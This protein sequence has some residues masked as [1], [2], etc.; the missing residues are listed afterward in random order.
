MLSIAALVTLF[1]VTNRESKN[2]IEKLQHETTLLSLDKE[3][4]VSRL[5][6]L[7][8]RI[9]TGDAG[10][11][12]ISD[13]RQQLLNLESN[14]KSELKSVKSLLSGLDDKEGGNV[15]KNSQE[16]VIDSAS[17]KKAIQKGVL[18]G[19]S[20]EAQLRNVL[21]SDLEKLIVHE[22]K[23]KSK[24]DLDNAVE[25]ASY[26]KDHPLESVADR[27]RRTDLSDKSPIVSSQL[28]LKPIPRI[29]VDGDGLVQAVDTVPQFFRDSGAVP[30][31]V[32]GAE[33]AEV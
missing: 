16:E 22:T 5:Q 8:S 23:W 7:K 18:R 25:F 11:Q 9:S 30:N 28:A 3:A 2:D 13:L 15:K 21:D 17:A 19:D 12:S 26:L 29:A 14:L 33:Y 24:S 31:G 27:A 20:L 10:K 4:A 32:E 6:T 1:A